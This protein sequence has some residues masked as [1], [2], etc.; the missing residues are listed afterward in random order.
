MQQEE[1]KDQRTERTSNRGAKVEKWAG[2]AQERTIAKCRAEGRAL[3]PRVLLEGYE[4]PG[5]TY[6]V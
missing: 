5:T 3:A 6:S 4:R 2:I 1:D